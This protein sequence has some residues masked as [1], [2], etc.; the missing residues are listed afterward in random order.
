MSLSIGI[1][2]GILINNNGILVDEQKKI[3]ERLEADFKQIR[4][5]NLKLSSQLAELRS[6]QE[7]DQKFMDS[8]IPILIKNRIQ[9]KKILIVETNPNKVSHELA[10][11]LKLAGAEINGVV[12]INKDLYVKDNLI[13]VMALNPIGISVQN[14]DV[15]VKEMAKQ[16]ALCLVAGVKTPFLSFLEDYQFLKIDGEITPDIDCVLVVGGDGSASD[17]SLSIK[18]IDLEMI[19]V[20]V[21][22][23]IQVIGIEQ[24]QTDVLYI[25]FFK[26]KNIPTINDVDTIMG[27]VMLILAIEGQTDNLD[28]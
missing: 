3:V 15:V 19:R 8:I 7:T 10:D 28:I 12:L 26:E 14:K 27:Q 1:F 21:N 5:D 16:A 18:N 11:V 22:N 9:G 2:S 25:N 13:K 24:N 17:R 23:N 6:R 20:F 4:Q